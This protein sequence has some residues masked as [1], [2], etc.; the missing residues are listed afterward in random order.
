[1][2][3][4]LRKSNFLKLNDGIEMHY[5]EK[6]EG[7]PIIF[8]PGLTFSWELFE[9]QIEYFSKTHRVIAID[10]RSQGLS[11]KTLHGNDYI[12]HGQDLAK[13]IDAL[14]LSKVVL[15][16]WSTGN[17]EVWSY[18]QQFDVDKIEAVVT[19]DM[20]PLPLS[21]EPKCWTEGSIEDLRYVATQLLTSPEGSRGFFADYATQVM[22]QGEMKPETLNKILNISAKTPYYICYALFSNAVFSDYVDT[23]KKISETIPS[24][25]FIAEHWADIAEPFMNDTFPKTKTHIFGGHMMFY[26][27]PEEWNRVLDDFLKTL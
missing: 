15:V 8:I 27:Y 2:S 5:V 17:L 13:L 3:E 14:D 21:E 20:S 26:E 7:D 22:I 23:A 6:G 18:I 24:L 12:T 9:A 10:P 25:M 11:T 16:G 1:M 19:I 4:L